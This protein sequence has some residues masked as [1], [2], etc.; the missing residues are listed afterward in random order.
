MRP[1]AESEKARY[2]YDRI[3]VK[4]GP[5]QGLTEE[6]FQEMSDVLR[7]R[8]QED[9]SRT[10]DFGGDIFIHG[11]RASYTAIA[12]ADLDIGIRVSEESFHRLIQERLN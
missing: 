10:G 12:D 6:Q 5:P 1:V 11:S 9:S 3:F 2:N 4:P 8:L 7:K